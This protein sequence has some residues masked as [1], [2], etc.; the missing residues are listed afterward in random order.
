MKRVDCRKIGLDCNYVIEGETE[1]E[2]IRNAVNHSW[3]GHAIK[4]DEMTS[5]MKVK[6]KENIY[7]L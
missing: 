5:E 3:E 2:L 4:P 6:I 1:E 7:T